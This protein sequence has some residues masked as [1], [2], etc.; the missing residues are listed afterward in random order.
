MWIH[1][2]ILSR[3]VTRFNS[4]PYQGDPEAIQI[5]DMVFPTTNVDEL[6][7]QT[8]LW[9]AYE[10]DPGA[11]GWVE[12]TVVPDKHRYWLLGY[13]AKRTNGATLTTNR[14]GV[15]TNL[16]VNMGF[17][18]Y[19]ATDDEVAL[20]PFPVPLEQGWKPVFYVNAYNAGDELTVWLYIIDEAT[21]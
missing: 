1:I 5:A 16:S 20:L 6:L 8:Y 3:L 14:M 12:A 4:K 9:K 2:P 13:K 19:T 17:E 10:A 7:K 18:P 11:T 21:H 15:E